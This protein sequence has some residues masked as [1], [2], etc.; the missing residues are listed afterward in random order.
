MWRRS[1]GHRTGVSNRRRGFFLD[2]LIHFVRL[3]FPYSAVTKLHLSERSC[4][5]P[6]I[7]SVML[8]ARHTYLHFAWVVDDAKCIAVTRVCVS[9]CLSAAVRP[10]YC[11]DPDVTW[12]RNRGCPLVVHCW[13]D[14]QSVHRL[15]CY[16][17]ITQTLVYAEFARVSD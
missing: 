16:G 12:G 17:N 8:R 11:T 9:V 3:W 10:H 4:C 5:I 13:A 6:L 7:L 15:R 2:R 1:S 14:L